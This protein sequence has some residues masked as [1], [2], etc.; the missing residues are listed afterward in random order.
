MPNEETITHWIADLKDGDEKAAGQ[1]WDRYFDRL[2]Q[3]ARSKLGTSPKQVAD[4]E[5]VASSVFRCLCE[6]AARGAYHPLADREDLWR[7]VITITAH[8][9]IDQHRRLTPLKRGGG[10]VRCEVDLA[11]QS[12]QFVLDQINNGDPSPEFVIQMNDEFQALMA[13][14]PS[15][16]LRN[17]AI[18]KMEGY[19]NA[20]IA[21]KL[22]LTTR[23]VERKLRRIRE[24]WQEHMD[25]AAN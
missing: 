8:K 1:L 13:K 11:K 6:G 23:S 9:A 7:L 4:E 3:L 14:L 19:T 2:V 12:G 21:E 16:V 5:D 24:C 18:W 15:D 17:I 25:D 20:A 22:D 10:Q